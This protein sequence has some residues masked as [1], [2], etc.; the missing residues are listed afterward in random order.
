MAFHTHYGPWA[1]SGRQGRLVAEVDDLPPITA[2]TGSIQ[3]TVRWHVEFTVETT[4]NTNS[5]R[6]WGSWP[7]TT[8]STNIGN[9]VK[10]AWNI[11]VQTITI[12]P[13]FDGTYGLWL[14]GDLTKIENVGINTVMSV[15]K[16]IDVPRKPYKPPLPPVNF[17]YARE[18][19][20]AGSSIRLTWG[21][22]YTNSNEAYPWHNIYIDRRDNV[23]DWWIQSLA[24]LG[25]DATSWT[26]GSLALDRVYEY[27]ICASNPAGL[28]PHSSPG[29][30]VYTSPNAAS[31]VVARKSGSNI[32]ITWDSPSTTATQWDVFH[33]SNGGASWEA[34]PLARVSSRTWTHVN[35]S[36]S[37]THTY[38]LIS[39]TPDGTY[40][41]PSP[42]SNVV[43]LLAAPFAPTAL[44]PS[45]VVLD[46]TKPVTLTWQH[47]PSD[48]TAQRQYR[49][50]RRSS[51]DSGGTWSSW[52]AQGIVVSTAS[53]AVIPAN[54]FALN[55]RVDWRV[56]TWGQHANPSPASATASLR[57]S[58]S[59]T[60]TIG[61]PAATH[62]KSTLTATW[63]YASTVSA[64]QAAWTALLRD[65]SGNPVQALSGT[66]ATAQAAFTATLANNSD[67]SVLVTVTD[68]NGLT[69]SASRGFRVQFPAPPL[70][71][72]TP[73]FDASRGTVALDIQNPTSANAVPAGNKVFRQ[74][75]GKW[76]LVG[77][78]GIN[79][80][81]ID[82][83]PPS[84]TATY[85][86]ET[87]STLGTVI[88]RQV[89]VATANTEEWHWVNYGP[90]F[91]LLARARLEATTNSTLRKDQVRHLFAGRQREVAYVLDSGSLT[92]STSV[93]IEEAD[94][95]G[96]RAAWSRAINTGGPFCYRDPLGRRTFGSIG[97]VVFSDET[98]DLTKLAFTLEEDHYAE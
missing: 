3:V 19:G 68:A 18:G 58:L 95:S 23:D 20:N 82:P 42:S 38:R 70:P 31:N 27:R 52:T 86:V 78:V 75:G 84:P 15:D 51:L 96:N 62:D 53:Q 59:P 94:Q 77:E 33:S 83:I 65:A 56:T 91:S 60:V 9:Y 48:G 76:V 29:I 25:W 40:S 46:R 61:V 26:N 35:A 71:T 73:T 55:E 63:T 72:V 17:T 24:N 67:Y 79:T 32:T 97:R 21:P 10:K 69:A 16:W 45:G 14:R 39:L 34:S 85:L 87:I 74:T 13:K 11:R 1:G 66:G 43:Q 4:D 80:S 49:I 7:D 6:T 47:V 89:T 50:E 64:A 88:R 8:A 5:F 92:I 30:K 22:N 54:T 90:G 57:F 37:T 81:V 98:P 41:S 44:A 28:S 2:D 93:L 36:T 12:W